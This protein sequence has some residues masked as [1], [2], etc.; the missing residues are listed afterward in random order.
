MF[1]ILVCA[2]AELASLM[3]FTGGSSNFAS[4]AFGPMAGVIEGYCFYSELLT[5][6][7]ST[8]LQIS[9]WVCDNANLSAS[10]QPLFWFIILIVSSLIFADVKLF[11]RVNSVYCMIAIVIIFVYTFLMIPFTTNYSGNLMGRKGMTSIPT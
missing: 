2:I 11:L 7:T 9:K 5:F 4:L 3:P 6:A 8:L 1:W 10:F